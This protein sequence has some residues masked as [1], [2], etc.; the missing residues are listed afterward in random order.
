MQGTGTF[1][2][3]GVRYVCVFSMAFVYCRS[4]CPASS[5]I[6]IAMAEVATYL[7][8]AGRDILFKVRPLPVS[9]VVCC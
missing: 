5:F 6:V 9:Q 1:T 7:Y 3:D 4:H 2:P 8:P